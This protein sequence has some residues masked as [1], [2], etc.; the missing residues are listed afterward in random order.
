MR[1]LRDVLNKPNLGSNPDAALVAQI[2]ELTR[3]RDEAGRTVLQ[4]MPEITRLQDEVARLT[5]WRDEMKALADAIEMRANVEVKRLTEALA[6]AER[7]RADDRAERASQVEARF[8]AEARV[9]ELEA[10]IEKAITLSEGCDDTAQ[11]MV[12]AL[13]G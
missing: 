3:E 4:L 2:E 11:V 5:R 6:A 7:E 13:R 8:A 12:E 9:R 1:S 10:R